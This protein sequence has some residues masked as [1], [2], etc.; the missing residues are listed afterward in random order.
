MPFSFFRK[1]DKPTNYGERQK[2]AYKTRPGEES[3]TVIINKV[4]A[5]PKLGNIYQISVTGI[6]IKN[7]AGQRGVQ[8]ELPHFPVSLTTLEQSLTNFIG[9]TKPTP[10]YLDGYNEWKAAFD[11]G[12]AGIFTIT[13]AEIV[14]IV[15]STLGADLP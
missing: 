12:N 14:D 9:Q 13:V 7:P 6:R 4:E 10:G 15:E 2:W 3:S 11:Q 8:V 1:S 5:H